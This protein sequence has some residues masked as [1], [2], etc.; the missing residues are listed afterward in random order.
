M[1]LAGFAQRALAS[2]R[3]VL[4]VLRAGRLG[5]PYGA[6]YDV[7]DQGP[8]HRLR[9]Y[10]T[11]ASD[12]GPVALLIPPL[13]VTS[14][15][16]DIDA[17]LS[18]VV[19]LGR[20]G[21]RPFV[22]DFGAPEREDGGTA[23]TLDD[24]V[25]AAVRALEHTRAFTGRAVHLCGYS[26]GGMFAYQTAAFVRSEGIAT[27]VTFGSPVDIH[28]SLPAVHREA[29]GALLR[30][31]DPLA[32]RVFARVEALPGALTS[33]GFQLLSGRKEIAARLEFLRN[34]D[35]R[36][37]LVRREARR[38]FLRG[39][40]FVA[41]PGPAFRDFVH[42]V[43]VHNRMLSGGFVLDGRTVSLADITCP[44]LAF[45]GTH[46]ELA[47]PA[48]VRAIARAAPGAAVSFVSVQAGHF[49]LVVGSTAVRL[50]WPTVAGW[51]HHHDTG[52]PLP[53]A[54]RAPRPPSL[55][56]EPEEAAFELDLGDLALDAL[57]D[58]A[59][60]LWHRVGDI[61]GSVTDAYDS[62]RYREPR[63]RALALMTRETLVG[64]SRL[65]RERAR[66]TPEASCFL[67]QGRAFSYAVAN[68]R[69]DNV[70][71]GLWACGVR[72]GDRVGVVMRSRPS[73]LTVLFALDRLGA[74]PVL[75]PPDAPVE[76][77]RRCLEQVAARRAVVDPEHASTHGGVA[78]EVFVLGG[79]AKRPLGA[80]VVDMEAI[81]P[82]QVSLPTDL[83][84]D[85]LRAGDLAL[86]LLRPTEGG[87]LRVAPVTGHRLALSALGAA[88]AC[89]LTPK[90]TVYCAIPLHHPTAVLACVGA[91]LEGGARLALTE[92]F[93]A[94]E[95]FSEVRRYGATVVFYAGEMLRPLVHG[96]PVRGERDHAI[97]LVAGS[98]MR[99]DL[100]TKLR[101]R[102]GFGVMEF[103]ASTT[104]R[105]IM[106]N[107]SGRKV[108]A[109]G[110]RMPG[111]VETLLARVD[112]ATGALV[113]GTD[114]RVLPAAIDEPGL[115]LAS[116]DDDPCDA[117]VV[118][119]VVT[120]GDRWRA[121]GDVLRVDADGDWWFVDGLS[122]FVQTVGGV[123]S[124]RRVE[125]A[126]Y[127]LPEVRL[128]AAWGEGE[129]SDRVLRAAVTPADVSD[130]RI[131]E[132]LTALAAWERPVEV[133]RRDEIPLTEGFRPDKR[134][135]RA[136]R[137]GVA[138]G[139]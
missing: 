54:L 14:E 93:D 62:V 66:A 132:A 13:M 104:Q 32:A 97:R 108:G 49:G 112:L 22:V 121:S 73:L 3:N 53:E 12:D 95:F 133:E 60:T 59:R 39:D 28:K 35:D 37:A 25:V 111:G 138:A 118:R 21:V 11:C 99:S 110:R 116:T 38:R 18:A 113:R 40:G 80:G 79:G 78:P 56:D 101:A 4:D 120:K 69:V 61:A 103:Y 90:D 139:P 125:D 102:Y 129:G 82:A 47:R 44:V 70:L 1:D 57:T 91:A 72:P 15:V 9:R 130:A 94:S 87:T 63:L 122:G 26:Q 31:L 88:A 52:A 107:A 74:V 30:F 20:M 119:D 106:A 114:G 123:V 34:L 83:P 71:K 135:L 127:A 131:M 84:L 2:T 89:T 109:L 68:T 8:H 46:D 76:A 10:A 36:D 124:T 67:W 134:A 96:Q 75:A 115:L 136:Q 64:P 24:H 98:G 65:L 42:Q 45:W 86:L 29:T 48:A 77:V 58:V 19:A 5:Q 23:R 105:V 33:M 17:E 41:W 85:T 117:P 126:L 6:P 7:I 16:Y 128:A 92:R 27:V 55:D 50:T 81:D 137:R 100:W 51:L 43:V